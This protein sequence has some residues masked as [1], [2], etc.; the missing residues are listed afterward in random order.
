MTESVDISKV[1]FD[2]GNGLVPVVVQNHRSGAVYMLGY[3]NREALELTLAT[4]RLHFWSRSRDELWLKGEKS[5]NYLLVRRLTL[6]CDGD[7]ILAEVEQATN[8]TPMCHTGAD[9]CFITPLRA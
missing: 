1:D 7:T 2:R 9:T 5:G 4:G 3:Q 8:A 6:D